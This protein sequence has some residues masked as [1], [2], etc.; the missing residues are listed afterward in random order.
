MK[1]FD[2]DWNLLSFIRALFPIQLVFSHLKHNFISIFIWGVLFAFI[3]D[4]LGSAFGVPYLF[5]SPEYLA[6]ISFESFLLLGFA[7]GG[8]IMGFNTY[9]YIRLGPLYP[10]LITLNRPFFKFCVN[11]ALIPLIFITNYLV[12]MVNFQ[13]QEEYATLSSSLLYCIA[14]LLG[15]ALFMT[16]SWLF[17]FRMIKYDPYTVDSGKPF[18]TVTYQNSKWYDIFRK[19]HENPSIYIGRKF[20]LKVSRSSKHFDREL[21]ST[22]FAKNRISASLYEVLTIL[23]FFGLGFF[24][25]YEI[26]EVP[27]ATSIVLLFTICLMLYSALHAWLRNWFYPVLIGV[28]IGMNFLSERTD[29][30]HYTSF[31]YG[32]DYS[33]SKTSE[34]NVSRI[35]AISN[36]TILNSRSYN[37]YLKTLDN[38]RI[39][40][41]RAK[42]KLIVVNTSG[43]GSRSALWTTLVLHELDQRTKQNFSRHTQLITGASGGMVGA[44]YYRENRLRALLGLP[45]HTTDVAMKSEIGSDILNQLSFMAST[46]DIFVRYQSVHYKGLR[47]TKDRGY[48]FEQQ[49]LENTGGILNHSLGHYTKHEKNGIIPTLIFTPTI[50]NDGRRLFIGAQELNFLASGSHLGNYVSN[51]H[52]NVDIRS[53]LEKQNIDDMRFSTVLR[54]SATFPFVMPMI[55]L[56]TSPS[57]QLMDAGIRDNYGTKTTMLF[58]HTFKD[59][60]KANTS[61][62]II[63][64]IRDTRKFY[65]DEVFQD[66][67]FLDKL[68]LPFGN[69]YKNFPRVQSY[70]QEEL[71]K[72][73]MKALDF[74]LK[75]VVFNLMQQKDDRISLSWHLTSAEKLKIE[76]ALTYSSNQSG[77]ETLIEALHDFNEEMPTNGF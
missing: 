1:I 72:L 36:D 14:F 15:I 43:G 76:Q 52:E 59:W 69:M 73:G 38:W 32:L 19:Q 42:P 67:S 22:I 7:L 61:G 47:Y 49:L 18:K 55:T 21:V 58:L 60:I 46:N 26:F 16:L 68:T 39:A 65:E 13:I 6:T 51:V 45:A 17:F 10:F 28:L 33:P 4:A 44:A 8:F 63:V 40:T 37:Q 56:P 30:F 57:T 12:N 71:E 66:V 75:T 25:E 29:M 24:N 54:A 35:R 2:R 3:N 74:P 64:E 53:L 31:A 70:N 11:N 20:R 41:G 48:G 62:V 34:Y 27:A 77:F 50:I 5:L 23:I 9:S